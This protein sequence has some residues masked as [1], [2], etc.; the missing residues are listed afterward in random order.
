MPIRVVTITEG[1][2]DLHEV[3]PYDL[4]GYGLVLP[5]RLLDYS[6]K[7]PAPTILHKNVEHAG[8]SV[9]ISVVVFYDMFM[10]EILQD[11]AKMNW[12]PDEHEDVVRPRWCAYTSATI[13]F[14]SRS[15][16]RSKY[17]SFLA[18]TCVLG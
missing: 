6:R 4:L 17:S 1:E 2:Q 13:C 15:D 7:V 16:I 5:L 3:I 18:N 9:D 12:G 8:V 14:L 11:I 10:L